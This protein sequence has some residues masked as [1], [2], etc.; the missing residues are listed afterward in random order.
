MR[1]QV[2]AYAKERSLRGEDIYVYAY[3][4][5]YICVCIYILTRAARENADHES[6]LSPYITRALQIQKL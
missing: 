5:M 2:L 6:W 3:I 1:A 4:Y